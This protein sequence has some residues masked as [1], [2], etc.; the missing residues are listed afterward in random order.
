MPPTVLANILT[1][2]VK[3]DNLNI[4][5][6][7]T[8]VGGFESH[9]HQEE[10]LVHQQHYLSDSQPQLEESF[11]IYF[12]LTQVGPIETDICK[13]DLGLSQNIL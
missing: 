5:M 1:V 8:A 11:F 3:V 13:T 4:A 7:C 10:T 2:P 9:P 6:S 12:F